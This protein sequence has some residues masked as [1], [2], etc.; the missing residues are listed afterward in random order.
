MV[1]HTS[2]FPYARRFPFPHFI[3]LVSNYHSPLSLPLPSRRSRVPAS[4]VVLCNPPDAEP[5]T[6]AST[7]HDI[8]QSYPLHCFPTL[9]TLLL[10]EQWTKVLSG[11]ALVVKSGSDFR[12][13]SELIVTPA[14]R[15]G[16]PHHYDSGPL[17]HNLAAN[18]IRFRY[19]QPVVVVVVVVVVARHSVLPAPSTL[20]VQAAPRMSP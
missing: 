8:V 2:V 15:D 6:N 1:S 7:A 12:D 19:L 5:T 4:A 17:H 9:L 11:G 3:R 13:L 16:T 18:G 20:L 14:A 10:C